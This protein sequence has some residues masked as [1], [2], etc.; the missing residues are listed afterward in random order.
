[1]ELLEKPQ[2]WKP[3][4]SGARSI[5]IAY[6]MKHNKMQKKVWLHALTPSL[7]RI[8]GTPLEMPSGTPLEMPSG[9]P[10]E[11][12]NGMLLV[13][14]SGTPL[15]TLNGMPLEMPSGTPLEPPSDTSHVMLEALGQIILIVCPMDFAQ[16]RR[17]EPW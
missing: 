17:R 11:I 5:Q 10:L 12:L 15:E 4:K 16:S 1:M 13:M 3:M 6:V 7:T 9:T 8:A 2:F 14:P